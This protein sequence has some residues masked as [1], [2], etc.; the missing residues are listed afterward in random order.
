MSIIKKLRWGLYLSFAFLIISS[1]ALLWPLVATF[2]F[3]LTSGFVVGM[4]GTFLFTVVLA[5]IDQDS[6]L[7]EEE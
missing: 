2:R 1:G 6:K 4:I 7:Y 3:W 5:G